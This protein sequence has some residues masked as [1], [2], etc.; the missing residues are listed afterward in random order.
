MTPDEV[1]AE[2]RTWIGVPYRKCG[3]S[4]TA[5]VDCLG[6]LVNVGI[7]FQVPHKDEP[8]YSEW[9]DP[10]YRILK[11]L[12]RYLRIV[13][14][15]PRPGTV[16][17]FANSK[18]PGH[19]GFFSELNGRLHVIHARMDVRKVAEHEFQHGRFFTDAR[20]IRLYAFPELEI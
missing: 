1:V 6:L 16:G 12:S 10:H 20:L 19:V 18:L 2:A 14:G 9:P 7:R 13:P 11:T 8:N 5:G 4:R 3:R 17:V 15:E